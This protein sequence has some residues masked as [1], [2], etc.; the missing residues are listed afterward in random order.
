MKKASIKTALRQG[1]AALSIFL[2]IAGCFFNK[3]LYENISGEIMSEEPTLYSVVLSEDQA[4]QI[5]EG[6]VEE[7]VFIGTQ[8]ECQAEILMLLLAD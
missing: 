5:V 1:R 3:L 2:L 4:P 7:A 8:E 6:Q